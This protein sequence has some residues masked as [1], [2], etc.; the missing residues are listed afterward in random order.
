[1]SIVS[2]RSRCQL[3]NTRERIQR[4]HV[5]FAKKLGSCPEI[6]SGSNV[7]GGVEVWQDCQSSAYSI[8]SRKRRHLINKVHF[9]VRYTKLATI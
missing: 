1:M 4:G 9:Y 6:I 2:E 5:S 7:A 8:P 3:A